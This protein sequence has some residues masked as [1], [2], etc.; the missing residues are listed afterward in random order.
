[1]RCKIVEFNSDT[2]EFEAP[3]AVQFD[4]CTTSKPNKM[5]PTRFIR[6]GQTKE[7]SVRHLS[8]DVAVQMHRIKCISY[9][10]VY[11]II[12]VNGRDIETALIDLKA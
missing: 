4:D 7:T 11:L 8:L 12:T 2:I 10:N 5:L 6:L 1:M 9:F 3:Q